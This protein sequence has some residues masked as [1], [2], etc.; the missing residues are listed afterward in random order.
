MT[1]LPSLEDGGEKAVR[2]LSGKVTGKVAGKSDDKSGKPDDAFDVLVVGAGPTGL[3]AACE[4][5]R[6]GIRVR[7]IDRIS[8]PM[9]VPRALSIYPRA[10]DILTD[11][12]LEEGVRA[13]SISINTLSYFSDRKL[14]A[15]FP[16][17]PEHAARVLPQYET[18]RLLTERLHALGGKV[19]RG[20]K[21]LALEGVDHSGRIEGTDPVTAVLELGD[22]TLERLRAPYVIGAD[23]AG[24]TVRGQLGIGFQGSTY[25]L[26]FA[27]IDARVE[28]D[29][30]SDEILYYQG[31]S[32][33]LAVIPMPDDVFRF[34]SVLPKGAGEVDVPMMQRLLDERGPR[35]VRITEPV[36]T[37][38][39]RVHA[40]L[41]TDFQLGR[42]FLMGDAAHVHSPAGGQGM[43]NGIQD[44][45]NLGW[46]LA[47]VIRGEAPASLLLSYGLERAEATHRI[48]RDTDLQT[49]AWMVGGPAMVKARDAGFRLMDRTGVVSRYYA[50]LLAGRRISYT[51]RRAT[52][53]PSG[54]SGCRVRGRMPGGVKVGAQFPRQW[55]EAYG[56]CGPDADP[57]G[58][59]VAVLPPTRGAVPWTRQ[60][61]HIAAARPSVRVV[62]LR[63]GDTG[64]ATGCRRPGYVLVRPD[65]HIAAHGHEGDLNRLEAELD[66]ALFRVE[67]ARD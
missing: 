31:E 48:I 14:L 34:F 45:Q 32:G 15:S 64:G 61:E 11:Q 54:W 12:G 56:I 52:Q 58:W 44:A 25:G 2:K 39:F 63:R 47:S 62:V 42:V 26:E 37:T 20:V 33:T 60:V 51:P 30:P 29:L 38:I 49:R 1:E 18:E 41:A 17:A 46:K 36:W 24:S 35:G 8:A 40:R 53:S 10:L 7:V 50:S 6:R 3:L 5:L 22:G 55:A 57:L 59:T 21:L 65:G 66:A 13:A 28:G 67:R 19:E 16:M 27:L 43:N 23:G 4:L 9:H